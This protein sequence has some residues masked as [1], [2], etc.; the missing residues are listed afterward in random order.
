M[1]K[2]LIDYWLFFGYV[3]CN[4]WS[5]PCEM[6]VSSEE[7]PQRTLVVNPSDHSLF[8]LHSD[9]WSPLLSLYHS[10]WDPV[11]CVCDLSTAARNLVPLLIERTIVMY[12]SSENL[13]HFGT[14]Y[15]WT[16]FDVFFI[17]YFLNIV[18]SL[19]FWIVKIFTFQWFKT[20]NLLCTFPS[21]KSRSFVLIVAGC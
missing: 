8:L 5:N 20:Y 2:F 10:G 4:P 1:K 7:W 11:Y 3:L 13:L 17:L 21:S 19:L 6:P 16:Y 12:D 14:Y 18:C 15:C 9:I